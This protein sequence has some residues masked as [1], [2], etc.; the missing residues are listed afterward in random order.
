MHWRSNDSTRHDRVGSVKQ[1]TEVMHR[2]ARRQGRPHQP[3]SAEPPGAVAPPRSAAPA[4]LGQTS[5]RASVIQGNTASSNPDRRSEVGSIQRARLASLGSMDPQ[6]SDQP[7]LGSDQHFIYTKEH[8]PECMTWGPRAGRTSFPQ[9][10]DPQPP[11]NR[12][13]DQITDAQSKTVKI[14]GPAALG[15]TVAP[16]C[17]PL[18]LPLTYKYPLLQPPTY[19]GYKLSQA[20]RGRSQVIRSKWQSPPEVSIQL[21][22]IESWVLE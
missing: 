15:D 20:P 21:V 12:L 22:G 3:G 8:A 19:W 10:T 14:I 7:T 17:R 9:Q 11:S 4:Q 13:R 5:H 1:T 18:R 2:E 16:P 6:T